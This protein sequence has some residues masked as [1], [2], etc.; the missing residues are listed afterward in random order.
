MTDSVTCARAGPVTCLND[1]AQALE[2]QILRNA[3]LSVATTGRTVH[4]EMVSAHDAACRIA[5]ALSEPSDMAT[6]GTG[7]Q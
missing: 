6:G 2:V 3:P 5:G 4:L 7:N 1:V